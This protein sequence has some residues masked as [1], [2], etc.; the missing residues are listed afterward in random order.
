MRHEVI[1]L[2]GLGSMDGYLH[3]PLLQIRPKQVHGGKKKLGT[4]RVQVISMS[5][6]DIACHV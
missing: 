6:L 5:H 2:R 3:L 4:F 1:S